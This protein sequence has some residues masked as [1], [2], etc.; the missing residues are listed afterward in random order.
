M[1]IIFEWNPVLEQKKNSLGIVSYKI[2]L[3]LWFM[4]VVV[5]YMT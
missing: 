2:Q 4:Y 1:G 5:Q 3:F